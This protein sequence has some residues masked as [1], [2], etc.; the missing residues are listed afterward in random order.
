MTKKGRRR[1][2]YCM[3]SIT[4]PFLVVFKTA[5]S[6]FSSARICMQTVR[7]TKPTYPTQIPGTATFVKRCGDAT[8]LGGNFVKLAFTSSSVKVFLNSAMDSQTE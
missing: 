7:F 2:Y 8:V 4:E 1:L 3:P 6:F 5:D